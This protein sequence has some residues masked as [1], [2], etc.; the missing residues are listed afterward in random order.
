VPIHEI[1]HFYNLALRIPDSGRRKGRKDLGNLFLGVRPSSR[2]WGSNEALASYR[3][4]CSGD[5]DDALHVAPSVL[6]D[7]DDVKVQQGMVLRASRLS[8]RSRDTAW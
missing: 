2:A 1:N 3:L 5:R 7:V 8:E 6:L 4:S